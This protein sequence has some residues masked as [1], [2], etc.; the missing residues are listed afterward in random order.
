VVAQVEREIDSY[1]STL[2]A[3]K[4]DA[5]AVVVGLK[6]VL[7]PLGEFTEESLFASIWKPDS[8]PPEIGCKY[9]RVS[10]RNARRRSERSLILVFGIYKEFNQ[11]SVALRAYRAT[12]GHFALV[13][14]TGHDFNH[15]GRLSAR[16]L[17]SVRSSPCDPA[18][19]AWFLISGQNITANGPNIRM[20]A[21]SFDGWK[22]QPVWMPEN[23]W[24]SWTITVTEG[25]FIVD[26]NWY[27]PGSNG[28]SRHDEY[29]V[30]D[31]GIYRR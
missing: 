14:A 30:T 2:D 4:V 17:H 31:D 12:D 18:R 16:E 1:V 22:L 21:Y 9:S 26:G 25:G 29:A 27:R 28:T 19:Q 5:N 11:S 24:G 8:V 15:Y 3:T 23:T 13:D 10:P 7:M 6:D 20:R